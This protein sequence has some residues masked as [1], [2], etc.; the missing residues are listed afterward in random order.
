MNSR[1]HPAQVTNTRLSNLEDAYL[2]Q[3]I[4]KDRYLA[5]RDDIMGQMA[6]IKSA[7]A[8]QPKT[9]TVD[10]DQL[11]AIAGALGVDT[12]DDQAWREIVENMVDRVTI[13]GEGDGRKTP[14]KITV[15]WKP[16]YAALIIG[17]ATIT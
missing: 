9:A 4:G 3:A 6:D 7:M 14:P 2:D 1:P 12:L 13:E 11:F 16:E 15:G 5:K 10:L 8:A 17:A